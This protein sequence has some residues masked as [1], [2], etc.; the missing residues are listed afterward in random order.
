MG[1]TNANQKNTA[2]DTSRNKNEEQNLINNSDNEQISRNE[3]TGSS[4][5]PRLGG[6][7]QSF[8][9]RKE[10]SGGWKQFSDSNEET[11]KAIGG[12]SLLAPRTPFDEG[13]RSYSVTALKKSPDYAGSE[14]GSGYAEPNTFLDREGQKSWYDTTSNFDVKNP[15]TTKIIEWAKERDKKG[16][17]P[18]K[19][20]DFV[21]CQHWQKIPN[22]YMITLRRYP[23]PITDNL[24]FP[25]EANDDNKKKYPPMA[26]AITYLG[27]D[28]EN[29]I[30]DIVSF[31]V[32]LPYED[33]EADVHE[34]SGQ[35][36]GADA[37]GP[38]AG[39]AKVLGILSGDANAETIR[40]GG[41]PPADP[42][43]NGPYMNKILGPVNRIDKTKQR[44]AGLEFEQ[45]FTIKFH[46]RSRPIGGAN[47]KAVMLDII[48]NLLLLTYAEASFW[49]GS[50]RFTGGSPQYPFLGGP[51]GFDAL[52]KGD[53]G[54]FFDAFTDQL[55]RA[56][57]TVSD[58]FSSI[59]S[60]DPIEGL[61]NIA[62]GA[63][64]LGI[65]KML[66]GKKDVALQLPALLTGNPVGNWHMTIGNPFNPM[67]EIGNL[68]CTGCTF[69]LGNE[70][71]PD[72]FPL[73]L[74]AEITLEHGMPR[75]SASAQSMFNRG[76]G[77]IYHIPDEYQFGYGANATMGEAGSVIDKATAN[78]GKQSSV[79][80]QTKKEKN[81]ANANAAI[82]GIR[83][84]G[85]II[86]DTGRTVGKSTL[87][88]IKM[89][90]GYGTK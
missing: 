81:I 65:A 51:A 50:H 8:Q 7:G 3:G 28:P 53:M 13:N 56:G 1:Q 69:T 70:L 45:S 60:G 25:G 38:A 58:I 16:K 59:I 42:Y 43:N 21:F 20:T 77:K 85:E 31:K 4:S 75:D 64:E 27:E 41:Q 9:N 2:Q 22:N 80:K 10:A 6:N 19:Y 40:R 48:A 32:S 15:T 86:S 89:G 55:S 84:S 72:D 82:D 17:R 71:G 36:A 79:N 23:Y 37:A 26:Q 74:T 24:Q 62:A 66:A 14:N 47:T 54:G 12:D 35:T 5:D 52:Y 44:G 30:S 34:I 83:K 29:S 68:V 46:Y 73:D 63:A 18:Y 57:E 90:L 39:F 67:M 33:K 88:A 49:G 11:P 61:K 76:G 78:D 87:E